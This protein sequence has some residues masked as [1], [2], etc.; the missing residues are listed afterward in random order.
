MET[1]LGKRIAAGRKRMGL[2]QDQLAERL[3]VTAQAVSKWENDQSCPDITML[4]RLAEIFG[5]TT[6][7]LLGMT[8]EKVLEAQVVEPV[9]EERG[10]RYEDGED[11]KMEFRRYEDGKMEF[12]YDSGRRPAVGFA[13]WVLLVGI[14][15]AVNFLRTGYSYM[16]DV[17][18]PAGLLVFGLYGLYPKFSIWRLGCALFGGYALLGYYFTLTYNSKVLLPIILV[19]LGLSLLADALRKPGKPHFSIHHRDDKPQSTIFCGEDHFT[20]STTFGEA[21]RRIELH[22]LTRGDASVSFGELEVDITGCKQIAPDC[23]LDLRCSF[24]ELE[25][26]VPRTCQVRNN[27]SSA[28]ASVE[29]EG[30][31]N[32]DAPDEL[33]LNCD[34]SFGAICVKYI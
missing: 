17:A 32:A 30:A 21:H 4:P 34:V 9:S 23:R 25:L 27:A 28:F 29:I 14:L 6:D 31:P 12:R 3:G 5:T 11:G 8:E 15:T 22:R 1:T 16:W 18:W 19:L 2:T 13:L 24:G 33:F 26:L 20:C 7:M 10:F